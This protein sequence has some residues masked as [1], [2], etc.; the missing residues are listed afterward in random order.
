MTETNQ[1]ERFL[2]FNLGSEQYAISLRT[3]REVIAMPEI[4]PI[5][6]SQP[7]FLGIMNL[8]GQ[9]ISIV[10]LRLKFGIKSKSDAETAVIICDLSPYCLGVV[11]DSVN[12]VQCPSPSELSDK[13]QVQSSRNSDYITG[14]YRKDERLIVLIDLMKTLSL[15]DRRSMDESAAQRKA[16]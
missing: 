3:V 7:H 10:D 9:V 14:I 8:R 6:H 1:G 11:V 5:P 16:G 13:P 15:E 4:T 2:N 12:A